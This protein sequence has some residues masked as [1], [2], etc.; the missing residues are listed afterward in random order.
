MPSGRKKLKGA[1]WSRLR[2]DVFE[3]DGFRCQHCG[4]A[5]RLEAHH[6]I[7]T[8]EGGA[9]WDIDNL[10]TVCRDCHLLE[11]HPSKKDRID[12]KRYLNN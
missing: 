7:P 1:R 10:E 2:R 5:G 3:R 4:G 9:I 11:H 12:W 6:I 8:S